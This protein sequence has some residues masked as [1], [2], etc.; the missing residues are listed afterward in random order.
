MLKLRCGL[1][2]QYPTTSSKVLFFLAL[3][4]EMFNPDTRKFSLTVDGRVVCRKAFQIFWDIGDYTFKK[5][6]RNI[7][8]N[9]PL[10]VIHGNSYVHDPV[11]LVRCCDWLGVL[12]KYCEQQP[13]SEEVHLPER[14]YKADVYEEMVNDL[15]KT[16][17]TSEIPAY[18]TFCT[19]WRKH[20]PHLKIPRVNRL[21]RCDVCC[22]FA[23]KIKVAVGRGKSR[24][25]AE[26]QKHRAQTR[27]ERKQISLL[28]E[29]TKDD[30]E[31]WTSVCTDWSAPHF[32]PHRPSQPKGWMAKKRPK[33][34]LFGLVNRSHNQLYL[35][36][37]FDFWTHDA[38]L[39]LSFLYVYI[40]K[41]KQQNLLGRNLIIQMD[42][43]WRDNKNKFFL[44]FAAVLVEKKIF[45]SVEIYYLQPGHSHDMVDAE[46]FKPLGNHTRFMYGYWTPEEFISCF[47]NK[48][49]NRSPR[50]PG[51]LEPCVWDWKEWLLPKLRNVSFHT[52][53]RAFKIT[54]QDGVPVLFYKA[55]VLS[56]TWKGLENSTSGLQILSEL[57][58]GNPHLIPP[59]SLPQEDLE[60]LPSLTS[61]PAHIKTFWRDFSEEQF[62]ESYG[63]VPDFLVTDF[64][65]VPLESIS[66]SSSSDEESVVERPI[67][68]THHPTTVNL[69]PD[70]LQ[71][72]LAVRVSEEFYVNN[73]ED[74]PDFWLAKLVAILPTSST[75]NRK[76]KVQWY[77]NI[78]SANNTNKF[79]LLEDTDDILFSAVIWGNIEL[80]N[81]GKIKTAHERKIYSIMNQ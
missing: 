66:S 15:K 73:P 18:Q 26:L 36:P 24:L 62:S 49:W 81:T 56:S 69:T 33:Y 34:H 7:R 37:H 9:E 17:P 21:G 52:F 16:L 51:F 30:K 27:A 10:S 63:A 72:N 47:I 60:D 6:F 70:L 59:T 71:K 28:H 4:Q 43:C 5:L 44:G 12:E 22:S 23:E 20:Y 58:E 3:L 46:C 8:N 39:H 65:G 79:E 75:G 32:M 14:T 19:A 55:S 2:S 29:K 42:N 41:M 76:I 78:S 61:M 45:S 74:K 25:C 57:P 50:K 48:A 54:M 38:N 68:V 64:W 67:H 53:Q 31:M 40:Q 77:Q 1:Q 35:L 13:D 80:T 11:K